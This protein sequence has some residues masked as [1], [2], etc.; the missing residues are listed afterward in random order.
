MKI[1]LS[2]KSADKKSA[3]RGTFHILLILLLAVSV[4]QPVQA[5]PADATRAVTLD[6]LFRLEE[7]GTVAL[8][9]NGE[10]LAYV[11]KRA[12]ATAKQFK[13]DYLINN[14][15]ADIWLVSTRGG[16]AENLTNG[17]S[18]DSGYWAPLW[19]PDG[20]R[21]AFLSTKG[22]DNVRLWVWER[23]TRKI[24]PLTDRG[25]EGVRNPNIFWI[26]NEEL[27]CA[28][29]LSEGRRP[30]TMA[31]EKQAAE[32]AI[33]EW[34]KAWK[35]ESL[36]A[37][38]LDSGQG[39]PMEQRP[40]ASLLLINLNK[41]SRTVL[42]G[43]SF[44]SS[45][46][47]FRGIH[48]APDKRKFAVVRQ[49]SMRQPE[50][51]KL[52]QPTSNLLHQVALLD[53]QRNVVSQSLTGVEEVRPGSLR[54]S[55]N[56][57]EIALMGY[58]PDT[59]ASLP[60]VFRCTVVDSACRAV[61]SPN[62]DFLATP[63]AQPAMIWSGTNQLIVRAK[64]KATSIQD[65]KDRW[66]WWVIE[67]DQPARNLTAGMKSSPGQ[68]I[69]E[70][71]GR[72]FVGLSEG[73]LWR[74]YL[75]GSATRDLTES[76]ETKFTSIAWPKLDTA[77]PTTAKQLILSFTKGLINELY[78]IDLVSGR[79]TPVSQP[80][81]T[82][83]LLDYDPN[84]Q[85]AILQADD[86]TGTYLWLSQVSSGMTTT[87]LETNVF[88]RQISEGQS[89]KIKYRALDGSDLEAW[90]LLPPAYQEGKQYPVVTWVYAGSMAG[91]APSR[92]TSLNLPH[93]YNLQLLAAHGYV[94][95][96]PSMPL[97]PDGQASDPYMDLTNGVL[98]AVDK[99]AEM[100][101]ADPKRVGVMGQSFGGF[102]TYGLITQTKRFQAAVA[103]AG[104]SDLVSLYGIFDVRFRYEPFAHEDPFRM[105]L[106]ETGQ[107]R[108]GNPPWK[109]WG[110]YVRNSPLFY[111]DR[112]ETPLLIIQGD[113]DF[114]PMQQ[115]EQFFTAL[116]RQSKRARFV[117]YWGE[118]HIM[119]SPPN[120]RDMWS[121]IFA[122]FDEFLMKPEGN[123]P[124]N[125]QKAN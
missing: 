56:G 42:T 123:K 108:M 91:E 49:V 121:Q 52:L 21:L 1:C 76:M 7:V 62:L 12:K 120:I 17:V 45:G 81:K 22:G 111:V 10:S 35:G 37:N 20:Q 110:R 83:S 117:R 58:A 39:M 24:R 64:P 25:V 98:P 8:S 69:G 73:H 18:D 27:L 2:A 79:I 33:K 102:S 86:R 96:L 41:G 23:A 78:R 105:G 28:G 101:I 84:R 80:V 19:S 119:Q 94:V 51:D 30:T 75:D 74:I 72:S 100:G 4:A 68:L 116:Y 38:V 36:T 61:K 106:A 99:L 47:S 55:P 9:P 63:M 66:D 89:R 59:R 44:I 112:V 109:D 29:V 88:L 125:E 113:M 93:G 31:V 90:V 26:S 43:L 82:A 48:P 60:Q 15:H 5:I 46:T 107:A 53:S 57:Q 114:V 40:H 34:P 104:L 70:D 65:K 122:W 14:D 6:D 16:G 124:A 13:Q 87:V 67:G 54:W 103:M 97:K 50:P 118:G 3:M 92:L 11:V 71:D 32:T 77:E 115:G 85:L 95:L